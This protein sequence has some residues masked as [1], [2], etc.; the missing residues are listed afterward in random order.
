VDMTALPLPL[1]SDGGDEQAIQPSFGGARSRGDASRIARRRGPAP[2]GRGL[3]RAALNVGARPSPGDWAQ[4]P[5]SPPEAATHRVTG[6]TPY[7]AGAKA[8]VARE[9]ILPQVRFVVSLSQHSPIGSTA[10]TCSRRTIHS[11]RRPQAIRCYGRSSPL[12]EVALGSDS[13]VPVRS[14]LPGT[15]THWICRSTSAP[16]PSK[17]RGNRSHDGCRRWR[18]RSGGWRRAGSTRILTTFVAAMSS[19]RRRTR[20]RRGMTVSKPSTRAPPRCRG[21]STG[22]RRWS[23]GPTWWFR[24]VPGRASPWRT[25]SFVR[26][27]ASKQSWPRRLPPVSD[28]YERR[29]HPSHHGDGPGRQEVPL[30][31]RQ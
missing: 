19:G 26:S 7:A 29:P 18:A 2:G 4:G 3:I 10:G 9:E 14:S 13:A 31:N 16:T 28:G 17:R 5:A 20:D 21:A 23:R 12:S 8:R 22:P 6:V 11:G 25:W 24:P 30:S 15:G 1:R 27:Q